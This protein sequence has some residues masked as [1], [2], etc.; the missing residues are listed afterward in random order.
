MGGDSGT[1]QDREEEDGERRL[2]ARGKKK[3][4]G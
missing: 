1:S 3:T 4:F 2:E